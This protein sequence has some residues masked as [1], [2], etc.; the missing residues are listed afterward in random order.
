M[1]EISNSFSLVVVMG[2]CACVASIC[3]VLCNSKKKK[4]GI[5]LNLLI[6]NLKMI[7]L[8]K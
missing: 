2:E 3:V 5:Q 6:H 1:E 8:R 7:K 4:V